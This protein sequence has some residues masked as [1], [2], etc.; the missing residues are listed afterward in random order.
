MRPSHALIL[1][2]T[3]LSACGGPDFRVGPVD[4]F[5]MDEGAE[6]WADLPEALADMQDRANAPADTWENLQLEFYWDF[7]P[8]RNQP[9]RACEYDPRTHAIRIRVTEE[10]TYQDCLPHE[11]AHAWMYTVHGLDGISGDLAHGAEWSELDATLR[12]HAS[13]TWLARRLE[14]TND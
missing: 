13:D 1:A 6:A 9:H 3:A 14:A 7:R 4:V 5:I 12:E 2:T 10:A 8:I 11:T